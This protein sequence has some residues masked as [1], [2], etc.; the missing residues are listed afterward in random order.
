MRRSWFPSI[1][2]G[3][4]LVLIV[5]FALVMQKRE[6]SPKS[7]KGAAPS[8]SHVQAPTL[9]SYDTALNGVLASYKEKKDARKTYEALILMTVPAERR[10]KHLDLVIA[11]GRLA[12][13]AEDGQ[14]RFEL[15]KAKY[16]DLSL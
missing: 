6:L 5:L 1:L 12:E 10:E 2:S 14:T 9:E 3:L 4:T 15:L 11:F 8:S 16:P 7:D 13:R